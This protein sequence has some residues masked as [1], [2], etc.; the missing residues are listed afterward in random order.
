MSKGD[1]G[2]NERRSPYFVRDVTRA[3]YNCVLGRFTK[4]A[5]PSKGCGQEYIYLDE[6]FAK[7]SHM[8]RIISRLPVILNDS[9]WKSD[10]APCIVG[11]ERCG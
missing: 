5:R 10:T 11:R 3:E 7:S 4:S 2:E 6:A 1:K 9:Q 8:A